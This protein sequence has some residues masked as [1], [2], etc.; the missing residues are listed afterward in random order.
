MSNLQRSEQIIEILKSYNCREVVLCSGARNAP[1]VMAFYSQ[2]SHFKIWSHFDERSAAFF[3]LGRIKLLNQAV[4][5]VTTSGTAVAELLPATVEAHYS[6]LPLILLTADRPKRFR[7]RGAPQA[8]EQVGIFSHYVEDTVDFEENH[9]STPAWSRQRPLHLNICLEEPSRAEVQR[10]PEREALSTQELLGPFTSELSRA[11][12]QGQI[13]K[14]KRFFSR[15]KRPAVILGPLNQED[16]QL[17]ERFLLQTGLPVF[18]ESLSQLAGSQKLSG[19]RIEAAERSLDLALKRGWVDGLVRIGGVPTLRTWRDLEEKFQST[20]VL[21]ASRVP[22]SGL[23][24]DDVD[25]VSLNGLGDLNL[26]NSLG[27]GSAWTEVEQ[28]AK[29]KR[30][31]LIATYPQSE[32][33]LLAAL[34]ERLPRAA[35]IYLGNSLPIREWDLVAHASAHN[36]RVEGNRG[37]NGIDGQLSTFLGFASDKTANWAV[38]GDLTTL[39]D[40]SSPWFLPQLTAQELNLVV[41]NNGGGKI[42]SRMFAQAELENQHNIEFSHWAKMWNMTYE[43]WEEIP[44]ALAAKRPRVIELKPE[45]TQTTRF[46]SEWDQFWQQI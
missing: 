18:A 29:K 36:W 2:P 6:G 38:L 1:L 14:V 34:A 25:L 42:F 21:V 43:L 40:L 23:S 4:A 24:R 20:P 39:Y 46:W 11:D 9:F 10:R 33:G 12:V 26:E 30:A 19:Q 17:A 15:T 27:L 7:G 28:M 44:S 16:S 35:Q 22:F 31:N 13:D 45:S 5:V 41:V 32:P 3:A 8:I 37:A